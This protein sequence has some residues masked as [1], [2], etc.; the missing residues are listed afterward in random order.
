[1]RF[2]IPD[3]QAAA[4]AIGGQIDILQ[5]LTNRDIDTAFATLVERHAD[6]LIVTPDRLFDPHHLV[7]LAA[8]HAVPT[9]Y[10][11]REHAEA[12]GLMSYGPSSADVVGQVATYVGRIL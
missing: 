11:F 10:P 7:A 4:T 6:A 9:I 3:V 1:V 8:R 2:L 5:V 12:G